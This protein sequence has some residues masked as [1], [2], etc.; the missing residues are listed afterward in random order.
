AGSDAGGLKV[1]AV[2]EGDRWSIHGE[3]KW[4]TNGGAANLYTV[5]AV[6]DRDKGSRGMSAFMVKKGDPGFSIAK[7]EDKMGIRCVPV[8]E[9]RF[10]GVKVGQ[11]RLL[12]G[13]PGLGFKHAMQ[14]LDKARPG[15]AAQ[16]VGCAQGALELATRY[17]MNRKQF[18]QSISS[19]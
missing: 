14:T 12:G 5:F 10:D 16:G 9:T 8:V 17:S 1:R 4:T 19:F 15:V 13:R 7:V 11:D 6:T 2:P 18:G 3:K